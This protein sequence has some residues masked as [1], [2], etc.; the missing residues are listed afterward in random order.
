MAASPEAITG[1][2]Q[3]GSPFLYS[4]RQNLHLASN[5]ETIAALTP[6]AENKH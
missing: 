2:P 5:N 6:P 1:L 3:A 4:C